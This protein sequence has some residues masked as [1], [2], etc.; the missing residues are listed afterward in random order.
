MDILYYRLFMG[1]FIISNRDH[2]ILQTGENFLHKLL[3]FILFEL[4]TIY[5]DEINVFFDESEAS[6]L[7]DRLNSFNDL[8]ECVEAFV[9]KDCMSF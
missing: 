5:S 8:T 3:Q 4:V 9:I 1:L 6:N 2:Q 7:E